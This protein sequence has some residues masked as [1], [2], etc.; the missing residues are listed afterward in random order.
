MAMKVMIQNLLLLSLVATV[1]CSE[2]RMT[3]TAVVVIKETLKS[4]STAKFASSDL[5]LRDGQT[6]VVTVDYEAQNTF[7]AM[8]KSQACVCVD[9]DLHNGKV[10]Q[11]SACASG[12]QPATGLLDVCKKMVGK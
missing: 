9:L 12:R 1:G 5:V 7:G 11:N 10:M 6:G 4:P 8:L 2:T 3:G